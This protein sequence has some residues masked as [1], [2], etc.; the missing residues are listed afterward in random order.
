MA[1]YFTVRLEVKKRPLEGVLFS[2]SL[3][4]DYYGDLSRFSFDPRFFARWVISESTLV[5]GGV[6]FISGH[7]IL[8]SQ[9]RSL[10][11]RTSYRSGVFTARL[12]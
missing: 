4:L 11:I 7:R 6:G 1:S 12:E 3:R 5:S 9:I 10:G 2:P 8:T